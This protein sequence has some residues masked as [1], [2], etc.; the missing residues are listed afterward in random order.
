MFARKK[1]KAPVIRVINNAGLLRKEVTAAMTAVQAQLDNEFAADWKKSATLTDSG[2]RLTDWNLVLSNT[3]DV[4]GAL[5]YHAYNG[6][7]TAIVD[8]ALSNKYG[9]WEICFGH[10]VLEM[11]G[12]PT[13][14]LVR[15]YPNNQLVAYEACD[16]VEG[17]NCSYKA[18]NGVSLTDF[19]LQAW[20][21]GKGD[22]FSHNNSVSAPLQLAPGGY[23]SVWNGSRWT[24]VFADKPSA[25][26]MMRAATSHRDAVRR[27]MIE[28][29][30]YAG[31]ARLLTKQ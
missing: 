10:E 17:V 12:D 11:V 14:N 23:I 30:D 16:A 21:D 6:I 8:V 29:Y 27:G 4:Q 18:K 1:L 31:H 2:K 9:P 3:I 20:F 26:A 5:G 13:C 28:L 25:N 15:P 24:Q 7:P 22:K 19:Q